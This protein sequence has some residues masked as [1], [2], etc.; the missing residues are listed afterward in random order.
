MTTE[1]QKKPLLVPLTPEIKSWLKDRA[2]DQGRSMSG[3]IYQILRA[4][5]AE[6]DEAKAA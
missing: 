3:E 5:K 1:P 2:K 4:M 6:E